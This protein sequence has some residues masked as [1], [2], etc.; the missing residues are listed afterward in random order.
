MNKVQ[1]F[2]FLPKIKLLFVLLAS[3]FSVQSLHIGVVHIHKIIFLGNC[4]LRH[5]ENEI[6]KDQEFKLE[7]R[8]DLLNSIMLYHRGKML[9]DHPRVSHQHE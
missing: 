3:P 2:F 4:S 9:K 8:K 5:F 1:T 6:A 7:E